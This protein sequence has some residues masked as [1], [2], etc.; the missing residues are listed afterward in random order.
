MHDDPAKDWYGVWPNPSFNRTRHLRTFSYV[1]TPSRVPV[2][3]RL[4]L[5]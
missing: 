1:F 2:A 4:T 5:R 3:H